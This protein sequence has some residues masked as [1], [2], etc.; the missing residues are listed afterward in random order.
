MKFSFEGN[1]IEPHVNVS[2]NA[3]NKLLNIESKDLCVGSVFLCRK[4]GE[5]NL[6]V[7]ASG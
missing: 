2:K 3:N 5:F 7:R 1:Q 4:K 6:N